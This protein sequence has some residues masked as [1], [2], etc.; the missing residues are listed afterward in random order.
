MGAGMLKIW[1]VKMIY[2]CSFWIIKNFIFSLHM[3]IRNGFRR[4]ADKMN[5][6]KTITYVHTQYVN[7]NFLN[8]NRNN[9]TISQLGLGSGLWTF[10]FK[11]NL[12]FLCL[13]GSGLG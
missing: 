7:A 8:Y 4:I 12:Y 5:K 13:L 2:L 11:N 3:F 6:S 9:H 1:N 10:T